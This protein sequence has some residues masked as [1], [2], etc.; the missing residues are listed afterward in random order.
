[1][2]TQS[3]SRTGPGTGHNTSTSGDSEHTTEDSGFGA[4][5]AGVLLVLFSLLG[6]F[7]ASRA[8]DNLFYVVG[9]VIFLFGVSLA[10]GLAVRRAP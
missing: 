7:M 9:L 6:L 5:I 1:M 8:V 10:I 2:T 4:V 3:A